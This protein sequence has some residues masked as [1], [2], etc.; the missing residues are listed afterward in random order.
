ME[1][2][3][4]SVELLSIDEAVDALQSSRSTVY[5]WLHTGQ[6][7]GVKV[8]RQWRV[9]PDEVERFLR[10]ESPQ[11]ASPPGVEAFCAELTELIR[12][13]GA[14][15][16]P[17][18]SMPPAMGAVM[19]MTQLTIESGATHV[20]LEPQQSADGRVQGWLRMRIDGCLATHAVLEARSI[21]AV[22]EGWKRWCGCD[23]H[24]N[25]EIQNGRTVLQ[26]GEAT[27]VELRVTVMPTVLGESVSVTVVDPKRVAEYVSLDRIDFSP[28]DRTRLDAA[29]AAPY[30]MIV[31]TG[32]TGSGKSSTLYAALHEVA[33][34]ERQTIA[35]EGTT[36]WRVPG[37]AHVPIDEETGV[38]FSAAIRAAMRCGLDVLMVSEIRDKATLE[39]V[40][41]VALTGHLVLTALHA[42]TAAGAVQRMVE[43]GLD[44]NTV[45]EATRLVIAQQLVRRLCD[46]ATPAEPPD[47]ARAV[48]AAA[49]GGISPEQLGEAWHEPVGC[50]RCAHTGYQ[51]RRVIAESMRMTPALRDAIGTRSA[52]ELQALAVADGMT[53]LV[54]DG[55]RRA[56]HGE[57]TLTEVWRVA[58][59][60]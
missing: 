7:K 1:E 48:D 11:I 23:P 49:S 8:G 43:F 46:C 44:P 12:G 30:G 18:D 34:P 25:R 37:V 41:G 36:E 27:V 60:G 17:I 38:T 47:L 13:R 54:A 40:P 50:S 33:S 32:P 6:L 9:H 16:M 20:S 14:E 22:V 10:G 55:I 39:L 4:E 2:N 59:I 58:G 5:R 56:S 24:K 21:P 57:T 51:G 3:T 26:T 45:F 42:S 29:L 28:E 19:L 53:T 15:P 52:P 35:I 31:V